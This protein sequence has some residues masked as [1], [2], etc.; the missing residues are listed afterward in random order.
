MKHN[1]MQW[2][3][4]IFLRVLQR[5]TVI[6]VSS[7][8]KSLVRALHMTPA[9]S[10]AEALHLAESLVGKTDCRLTIIPN[11]VSVIVAHSDPIT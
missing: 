7:V 5:A 1:R 9:S 11:G 3:A 6:F 8:E 2:Q 10:L 4:Q